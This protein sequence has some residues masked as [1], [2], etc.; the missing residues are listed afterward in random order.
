LLAVTGLAVACSKGPFV[1]LEVGQCLP[2]GAQ[3]EGTRAQKIS[4]VDCRE[5]HRYQVFAVVGLDPPNNDWPGEKV[6]TLNA[7]RLCVDAIETSTGRKPQDTPNDVELLHIDPTE[8][9]WRGGDRDVECLFRW[10]QT[11]TDTLLDGR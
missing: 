6:V 11:T 2:E 10:D 9:S 8:D 4:T 1:P 7:E 3:V 5:D